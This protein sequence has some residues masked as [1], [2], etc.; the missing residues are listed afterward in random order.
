MFTRAAVHSLPQNPRVPRELD[1][2]RWALVGSLLLHGAAMASMLREAE[3]VAEEAVPLVQVAILEV[4][5]TSVPAAAR[6]PE[7]V[8]AELPPPVAVQASEGRP[9]PEPVPEK[10]PEPA[11]EVT[12]QGVPPVPIE[13]PEVTPPD[14]DAEPAPAARREPAP[15]AVT[16]P[17]YEADYLDNPPPAYPRLSRRL[18]EEGEVELRVRVSPAGEALAVDLARSSG[19]DRLDQAALQAVRSWRFEPA[20]RG[21]QAVEAWVRVP[22]LFKLEA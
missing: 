19:S 4:P 1:G 9:K 13:A 21:Q 8:R 6:P 11:P 18:R 22:I 14:A 15:A 5:R 17:A 20:R 10:R 16:P 2:L 7:P 3:P 12:Q